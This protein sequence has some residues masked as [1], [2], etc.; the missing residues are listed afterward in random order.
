V[1]TYSVD[2]SDVFNW[3]EFIAA[4]NVGFV[5]CV[6]GD[7]GG[8]LDAFHDYLSWPEEC[9]YRLVLRGWEQCFEAVNTLWHHTGR[10]ILELVQEVF[11]DNPQIQFVFV[12]HPAPR[13][14]MRW[15]T[16]AVVGIA[17]RIGETDEL[18]PLPILADALEKVGVNSASY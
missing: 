7:W 10:P 2:L 4:F 6:N 8:N 18:A 5:R 9:P 12:P 3:E 13:F 16:D 1:L 17:T 11:H 14:D 15:R